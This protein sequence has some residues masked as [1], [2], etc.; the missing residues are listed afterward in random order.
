M[1]VRGARLRFIASVRPETAK[2]IL[3]DGSEI[4]VV[5]KIKSKKE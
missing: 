5:V 1:R 4:S 2:A 3:G